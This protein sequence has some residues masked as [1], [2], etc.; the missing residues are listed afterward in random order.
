MFPT[1]PPYK[2]QQRKEKAYIILKVLNDDIT[3]KATKT[4]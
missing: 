2:E 1:F 4:I 3:A